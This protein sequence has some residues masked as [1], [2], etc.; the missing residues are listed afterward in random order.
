MSCTN[1]SLADLQ[2][3]IEEKDLYVKERELI[4]QDEWLEQARKSLIENKH[5]NDEE[6]LSL[7]RFSEEAAS[8]ESDENE[9]QIANDNEEDSFENTRSKSVLTILSKY[10]EYKAE[11]LKYMI[12]PMSFMTTIGEVSHL[13]LEVHSFLNIF[14]N[15][16]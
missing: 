12:P 3:T 1:I 16:I 4:S 5:E 14:Q 15:K 9:L 13:N 7:E 6:E 11:C 2:F 8:L 10:E